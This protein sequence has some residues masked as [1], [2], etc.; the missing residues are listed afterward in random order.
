M[1]KQ[2]ALWQVAAT[3][4]PQSPGFW[5]WGASPSSDNSELPRIP[6]SVIR[7]G[8][9][10]CLLAQIVNRES[11]TW[12]L[13][14]LWEWE[15]EVLWSLFDTWHVTSTWHNMLVSKLSRLVRKLK[16]QANLCSGLRPLRNFK[17]CGRTSSN[18]IQ[19]GVFGWWKNQTKQHQTAGHK[20][21]VSVDVAQP[22]NENKVG[23]PHTNF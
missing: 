1:G 23:T 8:R 20:Q 2:Q 7:M 6:S 12:S 11:W 4:L 19:L 22:R 3:P 5:G 10:Y 13:L 18:M 9:Q 17:Q 14:Q 21:T 15:S 16:L